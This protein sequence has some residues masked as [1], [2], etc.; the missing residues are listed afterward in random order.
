MKALDYVFIHSTVLDSFLE[1]YKKKRG[2][3][4]F[5]QNSCFVFHV[6]HETLSFLFSFSLFLVFLIIYIQNIKCFCYI[7]DFCEIDNALFFHQKYIK[8]YPIW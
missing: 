3:S 8:V 7:E 1:Q 6:P 5:L 4:N 2:N